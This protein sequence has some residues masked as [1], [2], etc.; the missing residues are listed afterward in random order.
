MNTNQNF[1][2]A[3]RIKQVLQ[4][5][6]KTS[7]GGMIAVSSA[8][9]F[10]WMQ[11]DKVLLAAT[12]IIYAMLDGYEQIS[13]TADR[14]VSQMMG[15]GFSLA[16]GGYFLQIY[17]FSKALVV[18]FGFGVFLAVFLFYRFS[19]CVDHPHMVRK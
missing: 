13:E 19:K 12:R 9:F 2:G 15:W 10:Y 14:Y 4:E 16:L 1:V 18:V 5:V 3:V 17:L 7:A 6:V 11:S 8:I